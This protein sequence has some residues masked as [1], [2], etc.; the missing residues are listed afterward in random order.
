MHIVKSGSQTSSI[1]FKE[2][3]LSYLNEIYGAALRLSENAAI[4]EELTVRA[5]DKVCR[6]YFVQFREDAELRLSLHR[7]LL[8]TS[9]EYQTL[10]PYQRAL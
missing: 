8:R 6:Q 10:G 3:A 2:T 7:E 9:Y 1:Q 5:Y 4:A